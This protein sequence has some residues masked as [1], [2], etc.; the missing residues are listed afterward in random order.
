MHQVYCSRLEL[1]P[2]FFEIST[3]S[4]VSLRPV[5]VE[6]LLLLYSYALFIHNY[7]FYVTLRDILFHYKTVKGITKYTLT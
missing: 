1:N 6:F 5:H 2:D 3:K 4:S 7:A